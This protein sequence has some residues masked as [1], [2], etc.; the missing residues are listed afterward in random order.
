MRVRNPGDGNGNVL[1]QRRTNGRTV[2]LPNEKRR[3]SEHA[4]MIFQATVFVIVCFDVISVLYLFSIPGLNTYV[5]V[6]V[7]VYVDRAV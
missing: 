5:C 7:N 1:E 4:V 3:T 2:S 6:C